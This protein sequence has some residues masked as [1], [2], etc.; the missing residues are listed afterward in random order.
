M[1]KPL[2]RP[3]SAPAASPAA[4]PTKMLLL[5]CIAIAMRIDTMPTIE[6][7]DRSSPPM[8]IT[9]VSA[10]AIRPIRVMDWPMFSRLTGKKK[11]PGF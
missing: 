6:P 10:S 9:T 7:A 11:T 5:F 4:M 3:A 1:S 2:N 8:M